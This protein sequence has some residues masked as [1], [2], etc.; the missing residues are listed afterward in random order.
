MRRVLGNTLAVL[1]LF[2][3]SAQQAWGKEDFVGDV[4]PIISTTRN[5]F[6]IIYKESVENKWYQNYYDSGGKPI[7][8]RQKIKASEQSEQNV[9]AWR[10]RSIPQDEA[11]LYSFWV[12]MSP[13]ISVVQYSGGN[14]L[15]CHAGSKKPIVLRIKNTPMGKNGN[16]YFWLHDALLDGN[17][18]ICLLSRD[19]ELTFY[20]FNSKS[21]DEEFHAVVGSP[22][23]PDNKIP[24]ASNIE[25][26]GKK[27]IVTWIKGNNLYL[28]VWQPG[29]A[30]SNKILLN[31]LRASN[32]LSIGA[33]GSNL[34]IAWHQM[35]KPFQ[36]AVICTKF[37]KI[38]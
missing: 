19:K 17:H 27:Y 7:A 30:M 34:L 24:D 20:V 33:E 9:G 15:L 1:L 6:R 28:S 26:V 25:K 36:R 38:N 35:D 14:F 10:K 22:F 31:D 23:Y 2:I 8:G 3:I 13:R 5:G 4:Y 21:G 12:S 11:I 37:K 29:L 32:G 16:N 18:L